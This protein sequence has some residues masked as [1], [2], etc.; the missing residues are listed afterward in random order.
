MLLLFS[1]HTG[2]DEA[3]SHAHLALEDL[4]I[5]GTAVCGPHGIPLFFPHP[6]QPPPSVLA[7]QINF[8]GSSV[9]KSRVMGVGAGPRQ[10]KT[11]CESRV[12]GLGP[13]DL[14]PLGIDLC[15]KTSFVEREPTLVLLGAKVHTLE[16]CGDVE[17]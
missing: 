2:S 9:V 12:V 6:N 13:P 10:V 3:R 4:L 8:C 7:Q 5:G 11:G 16:Q 15:Q 14:S 17:F 1:S